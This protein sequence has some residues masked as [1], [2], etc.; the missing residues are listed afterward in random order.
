MTEGT[1]TVDR[2]TV[3]LLIGIIGVLAAI[4]LGGTLWLLGIKA[5]ASSVAVFAGLTGTLIGA[6]TT[7]ATNRSGPPAAL[8]PQEPAVTLPAP[9]TPDV[10]P[11]AGSGR[12]SGQSV[13]VTPVEPATG[14][15]WAAT[16]AAT[17]P[18]MLGL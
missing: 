9:T 2:S 11:E 10:T 5:D 4:G 7:L 1:A 13:D 18:G 15:Q 8:G 3:R 14:H 16:V 6:L 17:G 12:T